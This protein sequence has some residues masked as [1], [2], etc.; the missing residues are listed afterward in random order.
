MTERY[1]SEVIN[2]QEF[3]TESHGL[4]TIECAADT[5]GAVT[6][7]FGRS[8]TIRFSVTDAQ[9][10]VSMLEDAQEVAGSMRARCDYEVNDIAGC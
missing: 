6:V 1:Q 3:N 10:L 2:R 4:L 7:G 8:F 5:L 9:N